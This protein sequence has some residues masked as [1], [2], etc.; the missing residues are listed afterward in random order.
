M[1]SLGT[2]TVSAPLA[3]PSISASYTSKY[4][5]SA[6]RHWKSAS[7]SRKATT[8]APVCHTPRSCLS[9]PSVYTVISSGFDTIRRRSLLRCSAHSFFCGFPGTVG[10]TLILTRLSIRCQG[11]SAV[12]SIFSVFVSMCCPIQYIGVHLAFFSSLAALFSGLVWLPIALCGSSKRRL[13]VACML[14]DQCCAGRWWVTGC[15]GLKCWIA[16]AVQRI[17]LQ[18]SS[19]ILKIGG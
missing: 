18:R 13:S 9:D 2:G 7:P 17:N 15:L 16:K 8:P 14:F 6:I 5:P 1:D 3:I 11:T 19:K 12:L 10:G 4:S